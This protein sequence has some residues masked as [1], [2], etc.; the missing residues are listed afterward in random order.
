MGI[1]LPV[2]WV[3]HSLGIPWYLIFIL[4]SCSCKKIMDKL[5]DEIL[6]RIFSFIAFKRRIILRVVSSRWSCLIHDNSLLRK[7]SIRRAMCEDNKLQALFTAS[8]RLTEVDLFSSHFLNGSCLLYAGLSRLR[9]LTLTNTAVTDLILSRIL[10]TSK[11]ITELH[12]VGTCIS[13][14][15]LPHILGLKKL[16]YISV[17]PENVD[18]F[19]R[20]S[21]LALVENCR[22][23][24]TLDCQEGYFFDRAE[25]SRIVKSNPLLTGLVIPYAFIDN[26]TLTFIVESLRKL[27][28]ICVCETGVTQ[29]CVRRL[30]SRNP[31]LEICYN[32]NHTPW[33]I[34]QATWKKNQMTYFHWIFNIIFVNRVNLRWFF[35][36]QSMSASNR[37]CYYCIS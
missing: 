25:V 7:I 20:S 4:S 1:S 10:E 32:V 19:S 18:G 2:P 11:E 30:K 22:T 12:L 17:P 14:K 9:L 13:D 37:L 35:W 16:E 6:L 34:D 3:C 24:R 23:L 33:P 8:T 31:S 15:C 36:P 26:R 5:P 21:A 29:D 28:Y 27:A